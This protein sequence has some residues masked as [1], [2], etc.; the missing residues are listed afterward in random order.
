MEPKDVLDAD[1]ESSPAAADLEAFF[2]SLIRDIDD[3]ERSVVA[4]PFSEPP[5]PADVS[6]GGHPDTA[7]SPPAISGDASRMPVIDEALDELSALS[8]TIDDIALEPVLEAQPDGV[9]QHPASV[10]VPVRPPVERAAPA[11]AAGRWV[12]RH[13]REAVWSG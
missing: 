13:R 10:P 2:E 9:G 3:L 5:E 11:R 12:R 6:G 8:K 4:D 1:T 7:S